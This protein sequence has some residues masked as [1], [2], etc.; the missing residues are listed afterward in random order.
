MRQACATE[1]TAFPFFDFEPYAVCK[2]GTAQ[3]GGEEELP[4]AWITVGYPGE[5]P[6]MVL[7]VMLES[8]G[9]GSYEAGPVAREILQKWKGLGN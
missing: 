1:G 5:N 9:E 3:H 8:A 4:H 2:T 7:T 6:E